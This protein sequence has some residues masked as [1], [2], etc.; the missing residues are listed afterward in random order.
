MDGWKQAPAPPNTRPDEVTRLRVVPELPAD[1]STDSSEQETLLRVAAAAAGAHDLEEVIELAAQEACRAMQAASLSIS[2]WEAED[3]LLRTLVNVGDLGPGETRFPAD[4]VYR[5]D[6][7]AT[8]VQVL[9]SGRPYFNAVDDPDCDPIDSALLRRLGKESELAVA[10]IVDGETWG[11]VWATTAAGSR[12]FGASDVLFLERIATHLATAIGRAETFRSVARLAYEDPL[13]KLANRRA[14]EER[15]DAAIQS[16]A[17]ET[18]QVAL[19]LCDVDGLKA[20]NDSNGHEA[21]D[22]ALRR[23]AEALVA[24]ASGAEGSLVARLSGDE[25]CVLLHEHDREAARAVGAAAVEILSADRDCDVSLSCGV[26]TLDRKARTAE[27]LLRAADTA[28]YVAKRRGG[29]RV[30]TVEDVPAEAPS[31]GLLPGPASTADRITA[32][33]ATLVDG[34]DSGSLGETL[35]E[36][37][38]ATASLFA[39]A[40]DFATWAISMPVAGGYSVRSVSIGDNR[41]HKLNGIRIGPI[42]EEYELARFPATAAVIEAG[43]GRFS[44]NAEDPDS[45]RDERAVLISRGLATVIGVAA[46]DSSGTFLLEMFGDDRTAPL[47]CLDPQLRLAVRAAASG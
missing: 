27:Q 35:L 3:E 17:S 37:L 26:A 44:A 24:A 46:S 28:Q 2:R 23:V 39:E 47:R 7:H 20:I 42:S 29:G 22:R 6:E 43:C 40:A 9:R 25:F 36:R 4:E 15:L 1:P 18:D 33:I 34:F 38:E 11:E 14:L 5:L 13:T 41:D 45:D 31:V 21:G 16:A 32:A 19:L 12:R 10:I 8:V 30:C